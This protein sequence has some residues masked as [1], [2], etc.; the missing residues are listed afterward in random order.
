ML[1]RLNA[2]SPHHP[3]DR[4]PT[5]TRDVDAFQRDSSTL[6][7]TGNGFG[8]GDI[9]RRRR[10]LR[11]LAQKSVWPP[12][13]VIAA[14]AGVS[15]AT[16]GLVTPGSHSVNF[17]ALNAQTPEVDV[18]V[19]VET[20]PDVDAETAEQTSVETPEAIDGDAEKVSDWAQ[21]GVLWS[22]AHF[23]RRIAL[24][25]ARLSDNPAQ[26]EEMAAV[27]AR[28]DRLIDALESF[29]WTRVRQV[30]DAQSRAAELRQDASVASAAT[31]EEPTPTKPSPKET[32]VDSA[33]GDE[34]NEVPS[35]AMAGR[36]L[37]AEL[38]LPPSQVDPADATD[39]AESNPD[40]VPETVLNP[41]TPEARIAA[42]KPPL[43]PSTSPEPLP[44]R[45]ETET[46]A[47][48]DDPG[49][50]DE[51]GT[52]PEQ[53]DIS[54]YRVDDYVDENFAERVNRADAIEDGAEA[55]LAA[56]SDTI[57]PD[58]AGR[59]SERETQ[60]RSA[61][62]PYSRDSIYDS[63]DYDPDIDYDAENPIAAQ[64]EPIPAGPIGS[65]NDGYDGV[66]DIDGEDELVQ[67][68]A[69]VEQTKVPLN[70][71]VDD[72]LRGSPPTA[73]ARGSVGVVTP[74]MDAESDAEPDAGATATAAPTPDTSTVDWT[75]YSL[76]EVRV[77]E[78][79]DWVQLHLETNQ[80]R[81]DRLQDRLPSMSDQSLR[82]LVGMAV[83]DLRASAD[84]ITRNASANP[85]LAEMLDRFE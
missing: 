4:E 33:D 24:D 14:T 45:V 38:S 68:M 12:A 28:C 16:L 20:T 60:T 78:D 40:S 21:A 47:G 71:P 22:D 36:A 55:A 43:E 75:A 51:L 29:G 72:A 7:R 5:R 83:I 77:D 15:M 65:I 2:S 11:R 74:G 35:A 31:P 37:A 13:R 41:A 54:H 32:T 19:D 85:R 8:G 49:V 6:D 39:T 67:S 44:L 76:P 82:I 64:A 25:A 63:D 34:K 61:T 27:V 30:R 46:P 9:C 58:V 81:F 80:Q 23:T 59:I 52:D 69:G 26:Q 66:D 42:R 62:L 53:F 17:A 50:D 79:A 3:I 84:A 70:R 10:F 18:D 57:G 56:G 73:L 1:S 48:Q